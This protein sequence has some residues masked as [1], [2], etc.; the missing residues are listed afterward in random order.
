LTK[1]NNSW[2][3]YSQSESAYIRYKTGKYMA[4]PVSKTV[5]HLSE[6]SNMVQYR[7]SGRTDGRV[8]RH[9]HPKSGLSSSRVSSAAGRALLLHGLFQ[10]PPIHPPSGRRNTFVELGSLPLAPL[11]T[12]PPYLYRTKPSPSTNSVLATDITHV[13]R[14]M[15]LTWQP[16][17]RVRISHRSLYRRGQVD[18]PQ[19]GARIE[20]R[21]LFGTHVP[22]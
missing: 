6:P 3:L 1:Q 7:Y 9:S 10:T 14:V 16:S 17:G 8:L 2:Y 18:S 20:T 11:T 4:N 21:M 5:P 22:D 13:R 12:F 19:K 15:V